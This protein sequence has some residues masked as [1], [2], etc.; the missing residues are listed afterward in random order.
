MDNNDEML[1]QLALVGVDDSAD[2]EQSN[3][4]QAEVF[5]T[6]NLQQNKDHFIVSF[7]PVNAPNNEH[8]STQSLNGSHVIA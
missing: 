3:N 7:Q 1:N 8:S 4:Y 6:G 5:V 2:K